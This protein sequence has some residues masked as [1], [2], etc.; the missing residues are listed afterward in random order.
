MGA[1]ALPL[2]GSPQRSKETEPTTFETLTK[3]DTTEGLTS[4]QFVADHNVPYAML[5]ST[6]ASWAHRSSVIVMQSPKR[7][8]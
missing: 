7:K 4:L 5:L 2:D 3:V 6:S 1:E 8:A